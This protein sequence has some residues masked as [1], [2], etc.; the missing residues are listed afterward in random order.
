MSKENG[1]IESREDQLRKE[2]D[3]LFKRLSELL[4]I[5][6]SHQKLNGRLRERIAE[7]ED[8][9]FEVKSD[10]NKLA[11]QIDDKINTMRKAGM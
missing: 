6:E 5:N 3:E 10:N 9:L 2:V 1:H 4:E 7:L 8:E 11:Q